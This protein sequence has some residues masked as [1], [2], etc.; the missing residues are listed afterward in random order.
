V[1]APDF[2]F[3]F[4]DQFVDM[5]LRVDPAVAEAAF[6]PLLPA[7]SLEQ[8]REFVNKYFNVR[9]VVFAFACALVIGYSVA[10]R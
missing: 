10:W 3:D 8:L 1:S 4:V 7:P 2:D 6:Q 5:P 9:C